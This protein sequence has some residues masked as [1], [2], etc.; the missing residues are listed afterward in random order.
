MPN[1]LENQHIARQL[2]DA[3]RQADNTLHVSF[4]ADLKYIILK[5]NQIVV[6]DK[7]VF[8]DEMNIEGELKKKGKGYLI[9]PKDK[10][11]TV[12][13]HLDSE[14]V[15]ELEEIK[16]H[17]QSKTQHDLLLTVFKKG[18]AQYKSEDK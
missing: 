5:G 16:R 1:T 11:K 12:N 2:R 7:H 14:L 3:N 9:Q 17:V 13:L 18:L 4:D 8:S 10:G 6:P 15:S